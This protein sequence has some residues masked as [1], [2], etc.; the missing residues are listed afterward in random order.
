MEQQTKTVSQKVLA[1][2]C[3]YPKTMEIITKEGVDIFDSDFS[4]IIDK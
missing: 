4:Q 1:R 2:A 3:L